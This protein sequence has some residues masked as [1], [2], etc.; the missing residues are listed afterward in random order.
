MNIENKYAVTIFRNEYE[1]KALYNVGLSKKDKDGNYV[2]GSIS[3]RFKK[4]VSLEDK[5]KIYIKNAWLDFYKKD[6][7]T[8]PYIFINEFEKVEET[9]KEAKVE[10]PVS[11]P[12][13]E[14]SNEINIDDDFLD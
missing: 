3:C 2:N 12:F 4:D 7:V 8:V 11:D 14:F 5:T 9:I 6:K 13:A 1:G 10:Q